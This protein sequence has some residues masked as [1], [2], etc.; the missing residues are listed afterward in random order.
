[1]GIF[2]TLKKFYTILFICSFT[3]F[4]AQAQLRGDRYAADKIVRFYPNP[5]SEVVYFELPAGYD[6][7]YSIQLFNFMGK[8]VRETTASTGRNQVLLDGFYRGVYI[9]Q[10]RDKYGKIVDSGRFQV[11]R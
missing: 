7:S 1:L 6:K 5:A 9:Y 11:V 2:T 10:L 8:K 4:T 3:A